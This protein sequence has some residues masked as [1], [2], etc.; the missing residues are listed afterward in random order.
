[1]VLREEEVI[2]RKYLAYILIDLHIHHNCIIAIYI[3][4]IRLRV[5][6]GRKRTEPLSPFQSTTSSIM[7]KVVVL[8]LT[9]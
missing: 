4:Y 9:S 8:G 3:Y 6:G 2:W 1:M 5:L 7:K